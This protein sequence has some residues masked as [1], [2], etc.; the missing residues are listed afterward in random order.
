MTELPLMAAQPR[1]GLA[2]PERSHRFR[3]RFEDFGDI[4][5][6]ALTEQVIST[7]RPLFNFTQVAGLQSARLGDG[8]WSNIW[9]VVLDD[10]AN[11]ASRLIAGQIE[12]QRASNAAFMMHI[13][14]MAK[15]Y[16]VIEN[17][18]CTGCRFQTV[19]YAGL[20]YAK[21][22]PLSITLVVAYQDAVQVMFKP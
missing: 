16:A 6:T 21:D 20:S 12:R 22:E 10:I 13:E 14:I 9:V 15:G 8:H 5:T 1:T 7:D 19:P 17:W 11:R 4:D 18:T 2:Q 3:V